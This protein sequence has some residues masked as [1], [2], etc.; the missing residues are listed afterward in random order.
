M[1]ACDADE[2]RELRWTA[3]RFLAKAASSERVR[4]VIDAGDGLDRQLVSEIGEMGWLGLEIPE[5]LGGVGATFGEVVLVLEE[6]GARSASV[7]VLS[8]SVLC[9]GAILAGGTPRQQQRWLPALAE[10]AAHGTAVLPSCRGRTGTTAFGIVATRAM[11]GWTLTGRARFVLDA[12]VS[13]LIVVVAKSD[14]TVLGVVARSAPG[15]TVTRIPMTDA[16]RCIDEVRLDRVHLADDDVLPQGPD[17]VAAALVNRAAVALAADSVG[18]AQRVLT[19]TVEYAGQREQFGRKVGSFQAVKH[20]AA[21]MLVDVET[22]RDLTMAA[23]DSVDADPVG[24]TVAASMAKSYACERAARAVGVGLQLHGGI[25]YTWEHDLHIHLK[26][27][28][29][30]E[31]LVGTGTWHRARLARHVLDQ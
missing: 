7:P 27:A 26:R 30:N 21:D 4:A 1:T 8:S 16:T 18:A 24:A 31:H 20:Q 23:A 3:A 11:G 17:E 28:K 22:S 13:D 29:L 19:M 15:V 2:R 5:G 12:S 10:G 6:I 25:G 9:A 14:R